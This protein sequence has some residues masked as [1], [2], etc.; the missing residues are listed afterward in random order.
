VTAHSV[1]LSG[2]SASTVY[3][4]RVKSKDAAGNLAVSGNFTFTTAAATTDILTGLVA[5]YGFDEGSGLT[6]ADS[7]GH[8]GAASL[9]NASWSSNAK[10]GK[11]LSFNGVDSYVIAGIAALPAVNAPKTV[12]CWVSLAG[13]PAQTILSLANTAQLAAIRLGFASA[14][15]GTLG[16]DDLWLLA[17][18]YPSGLGWYHLAYTFDGAIHRFYVDGAIAASSTIASEA[19]PT[20]SFQIGRWVG[21]SEYFK[22][23]ID[24]VRIYS[25]ALSASEV[26]AAMNTP[27]ANPHSPGTAAPPALQTAQSESAPGAADSGTGPETNQPAASAAVDIRMSRRNYL[28][29]ETVTV[30]EYRVSNPSGDAGTVEIKT[31]LSV[32]GADPVRIGAIGSDGMMFL[33]AGFDQDFGPL[34]LLVVAGD[35]PMGRCQLNAR[36]VHPVTGQIL[37]EDIN[38]FTILGD[39]RRRA[40]S[41]SGDVGSREAEPQLILERLVGD[42]DAEDPEIPLEYRVTNSGRKEAAIELKIWLEGTGGSPIRVVSI[43]EDD[44]LVLPAGA[45]VSFSVPAALRAVGSVPSDAYRLRVRVMD[46][47]TGRSLCDN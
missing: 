15:V 8:S 10:F 17:A 26:K 23:S 28:P 18:N 31:W 27:I 1:S 35:A 33:P 45:E 13:T 24:E 20:T 40:P 9:V 46:P 29:G 36:V 34:P 38:R 11:A 25:R 19:G 41:S 2:L 39:D 37:A 30:A 43:G 22:G 4:Y 12:S 7:S 44:R 21:G 14:L 47:V 42:P 32:P 5:A 6:T 3:N 16:F